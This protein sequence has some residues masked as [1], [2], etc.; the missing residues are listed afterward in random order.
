MTF[1]STKFAQLG[2]SGQRDSGLPVSLQEDG[3]PC[4]AL[5]KTLDGKAMSCY[6]EDAG[7]SAPAAER[8][9]D[10]TL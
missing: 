10:E 8:E 1:L 2:H 4:E 9:T 7:L 5:G 6:E 3:L